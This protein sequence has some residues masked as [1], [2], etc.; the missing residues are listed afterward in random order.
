[1]KILFAS[2]AAV[3]CL[4]VAP[5]MA[6]PMTA[7]F[8]GSF[9][10]NPWWI[11]WSVTIDYDTEF[12]TRSSGIDPYFG[13]YDQLIWDAADG[14]R[15]PGK[16]LTI[17]L[18]PRDEVYYWP[19]PELPPASFTKFTN[20]TH[21]EVLVGEYG[22]DFNIQGP[23]FTDFGSKPGFNMGFT[24]F[25]NPNPIFAVDLD[26]DAGAVPSGYPGYYAQTEL[27]F[28]P[29]FSAAAP[30]VYSMG[31]GAGP[32]ILAVPEPSTWA[33]LVVAFGL[34]GS[35]LRARVRTSFALRA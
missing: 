14:G 7:G 6:K 17:S 35:V 3:A 10:D 32:A 30:L 26:A 27:N 34:V 23:G 28:G 18:T 24:D 12:G 31:V 13:A 4:A 2:V 16:L 33:L 21:F 19:D 25:G 22:Y 11:G 1:M 15:S 5:A 8:G 9:N 20:F 29:K